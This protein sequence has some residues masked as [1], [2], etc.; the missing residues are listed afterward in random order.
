[1]YYHLS[2]VAT[3]AS[4]G[5][6]LPYLSILECNPDQAPA[7]ALKKWQYSHD[8]MQTL[9]KYECCNAVYECCDADILFLLSYK[10]ELTL[11]GTGSFCDLF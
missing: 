1:M 4:G 11:V 7:T 3:R 2:K 9:K 10:L 5:N 6:E 8:N